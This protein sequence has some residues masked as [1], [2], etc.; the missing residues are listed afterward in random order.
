MASPTEQDAA[1][2]RRHDRFEAFGSF[3]TR[4]S[5]ECSEFLFDDL[6][7]AVDQR[8]GRVVRNGEVLV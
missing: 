8:L 4:E 6:G 1:F 5:L 2:G 3:G 7:V